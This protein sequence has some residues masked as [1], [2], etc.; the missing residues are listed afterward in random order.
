VRTLFA[1]SDPAEAAAS[2]YRLRID[3]LYVDLEDVAAYGEGV[4]KFMANPDRFERV[5]SN[6]EVKIYQIK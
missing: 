4:A 2:A 1:T 6:S 3:Y 5:F